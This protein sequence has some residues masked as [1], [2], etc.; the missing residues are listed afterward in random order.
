MYI[1]HT[2]FMQS[3]ISG[4]FVCSHILAIG[5]RATVNTGVQYFSQLVFLFS[6]GK[7]LEVKLLHHMAVLFLIVLRN[8]LVWNNF[9]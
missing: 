4:Y 9:S 8:L 3:S 7:Y 1:H 6:S 2:F 5:N